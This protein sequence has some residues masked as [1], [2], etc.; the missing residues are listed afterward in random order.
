MASDG[1]KTKIEKMGN[2]AEMMAHQLKK[3]GESTR[4]I[5]TALSRVFDENISHQGVSNY[6]DRNKERFERMGQRNAQ[7][8]EKEKHE[9]LTD[10]QNT[11]ERVQNL[12]ED[13]LEQFEEE[14][15]DKQ[16]IGFIT[17]LSKEIRNHVKTTEKYIEKTH[18]DAAEVNNTQINMNVENKTQIAMK[19]TKHLDK[20]EDEG[21]ITIHKPEKLRSVSPDE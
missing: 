21:V 19:I 6:F 13:I 2:S 17:Q 1:K 7:E 4:E 16:D 14:G 8:L 12:L 11:L 15:V 20:L 18:P 5:A 9:K 3:R 10:L